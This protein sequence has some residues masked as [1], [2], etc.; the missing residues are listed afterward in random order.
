MLWLCSHLPVCPVEGAIEKGDWE[1]VEHTRGHQ[2]LSIRSIVSSTLNVV[3]ISINPVEGLGLLSKQL[4]Y[5][6]PSYRYFS[7]N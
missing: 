5:R 6:Q 4:V 7:L 3:K 2:E 1:R